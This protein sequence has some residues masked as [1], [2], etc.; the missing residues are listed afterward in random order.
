MNSKLTEADKV[1]LYAESF[2]PLPDDGSIPMTEAFID[3]LLQDITLGF[4]DEMEAGLKAAFTSQTYDELIKNVRDDYERNKKAHRHAYAAGGLASLLV[5]YGGSVKL[6]GKILPRL[7]K[8]LKKGGKAAKS[9][10]VKEK[11]AKIIKNNGENF[12]AAMGNVNLEED[13]WGKTATR[14][15][16][17]M[18]LPRVTGAFN[19]AW[20][21]WLKKIPL[22]ISSKIKPQW[23]EKIKSSPYGKQIAEELKN[24]PVNFGSKEADHYINK[25]IDKLFKKYEGAAREAN[26]NHG[27]PLTQTAERRR[28]AEQRDKGNEDLQTLMSLP[29]V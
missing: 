26:A 6:I 21:G 11:L 5:P 27:Q 25:Y 1:L 3:G 13:G 9:G 2:E 22:T 14:F 23:L 12:I 24:L 20:P 29:F 10:K 16:N 18:A 7:L 15:A 17:D 4:A 8:V 28:P 19:K